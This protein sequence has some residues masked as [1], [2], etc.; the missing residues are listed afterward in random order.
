MAINNILLG[1]GH[2]ICF[3]GSVVSDERCR[4]G[5]PGSIPCGAT[6]TEVYISDTAASPKPIP[7]RIKTRL[8]VAKLR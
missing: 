5:D 4:L 6:L 7:L 3:Y 8:N 2:K 1:V